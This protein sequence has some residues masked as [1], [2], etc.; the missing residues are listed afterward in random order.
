MPAA[1]RIGDAHVCPAS[2]GGQAHA[3]G[4]IAG[5]P[6][7]PN[8]NIGKKPAARQGDS[9]LCTGAVDNTIMG[10]SSK[11]KINGKS[12]ARVGDAT[13]HGGKITTGF[14]KVNIG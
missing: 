2:N 4:L 10:G 14:F 6:G 3:G 11:V 9:C 12:A 1:A 8:V 7:S 13:K 5:P